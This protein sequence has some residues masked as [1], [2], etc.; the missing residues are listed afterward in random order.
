MEIL[1]DINSQIPLSLNNLLTMKT[2]VAMPLRGVFPKPDLYS[3][4][5]WRRVHHI[6]EE[7]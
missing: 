2:N 5:R 1:S 4:R 6:A 3:R 7:F